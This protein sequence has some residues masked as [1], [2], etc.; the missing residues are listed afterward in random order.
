MIQQTIQLFHMKYAI[1]DI[2]SCIDGRLT[3][4]SL[5]PC[6]I[7]HLL[8]DSRQIT[9]PETG[10]FF[11]LTGN[12]HNG[13]DFVREVYYKGVRNFVISQP[14]EA[15]N[16]PGANFILVKNSLLALHQL[17]AFHRQQFNLPL[18]GITGSNGKTIVKEWLFQLLREDFAIVRSPKSYNSQVGVPLSIWQIDAHHELGIIEAG[19]SQKGEMSRIAPIIN[20]N[21]GLFTN[22]G[23]AHAEGFSSIEEKIREKLKLFISVDVLIYCQDDLR[24]KK[25][26]ASLACSSFSWSK[27]T[28]TKADLQIERIEHPTYNQTTIVA[29]FRKEP[30]Q[31]TI[32]FI[33]SASIENAIHC[34]AVLLYLKT[35]HEVIKKRMLRLEPVAMR[36]E[37][38]AGV[39]SCTLIN[40]SY[41]SDLTS[42]DIA[43]QFLDQQSQQPKK[44]LILSD[45]LQSGQSSDRL[46]QQVARL[47][48]EHDIQKLIGIGSAVPILK[49]YLPKSIEA[50]F[51]P[52]TQACLQN[53]QPSSFQREAILLKGARQYAFE[54]IAQLLAQKVHRTTLEVD[55]N[56]LIHNLNV[57]HQKLKP[58]TKLMVMVKAAAYGSGSLEVARLLEF[59]QVD[60]LSVAYADE[61]AELRVG[62]IQLPILV[63]NPE[64][65]V[66][67]TLIRHKLEPEIYSLELLKQFAAFTANLATPIPIHLK[68][69][70]GMNRLGFESSQ[71]DQLITTLRSAPQFQVK[72]VFSHLAASENPAH[73]TFTH[74][75][76]KH[77]E[78]LYHKIS[79]GL[80]YRPIRHILNSSGITRFSQYQMDM[81]RL[82]I[83]LYGVDSQP[84]TQ[85]QLQRVL[86]LKASVSQ[87]K[88]VSQGQSVGYGRAGEIYRPTRTATVS[89]GYADGLPRAAGNGR[90][91]LFVRGQLAPIIGNVCMDMCMIDV[92][93]I[94]DCQESDE[95]IIFGE[96][97]TVETLAQVLGTIPYEV[98][99]GISPRVKRVYLMV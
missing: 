24:V 19:I 33:D 15:S 86:Q 21:L 38:K 11:A 63:L 56:A 39:N 37:L 85:Q 28:K 83:G 42:L 49:R 69:E 79:S 97:P 96:N 65:A 22:I 70:T 64:E 99:T 8:L 81:V 66:F 2:I 87:I 78:N 44:T 88:D 57:Y 32:P 34:W 60:Y 27:S 36:L 89:I 29:H 84:T 40:D 9:F 67:E 18:I 52:S 14:I 26:V 35:P 4:A 68:V 31:I 71:I 30:V 53:L 16:F 58:E 51:F 82:G 91:Q 93:H 17:A 47:I 10:L 20:C 12:R 73:D 62:G 98:F 13:H 45:I 61:G 95:V 7:E 46:Y 5:F 1:E 3:N 59:H 25:E 41:N 76:V 55:L 48:Q 6:E 50:I 23:A 75:Q 43:L 90:F 94:P 74:E 77:F 54:K 72:S 92:T 80:G